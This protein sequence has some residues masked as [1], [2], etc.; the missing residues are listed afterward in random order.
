MHLL[1]RRTGP[2]Q[3]QARADAGDVGVDRNVAH[4]EREQEHAGGR[5]APDAGER[6]EVALRL[7]YWLAGQPV[8]R[9]GVVQ[10]D[11]ARRSVLWRGLGDRGEDRLDPCR[12][13]LRDAAW[14]DRLLDLVDRR[15]AHVLPRREA[16]AQRQIGDVAVAVVGRLR[17]D[18]E[19]QLGDRMSVRLGQRDAVD[20]PQ[21]V[22]DRADTTSGGRFHVRDGRREPPAPYRTPARH[23]SSA[24]HR[25]HASEDC[26]TAS[27]R[28]AATADG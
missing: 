27:G 16:L 10:G 25:S 28:D 3:A 1:E 21:P 2:E 5:L 17:E 24:P 19:D 26:S 6:G 7:G 15:V 12:L 20:E 14:P 22:A 4:P 8:E 11:A 13:D 18:G 23:Y 9:Q